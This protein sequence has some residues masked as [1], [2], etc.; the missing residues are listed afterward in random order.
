LTGDAAVLTIDADRG[1]V[2]AAVRDR[3]TQSMLKRGFFGFVSKRLGDAG[4]PQTFEI[5]PAAP[6]S[7][8]SASSVAQAVAIRGGDLCITFSPDTTVTPQ[9]A[10]AFI[11]AIRYDN[12]DRNPCL[13]QKHG[14][15][16]L[17]HV[18]GSETVVL[19]TLHIRPVDDPTEITV[20]LPVATVTYRPGTTEREP[21]SRPLARLVSRY[22]D[23]FKDLQ[24]IAKL[25]PESSNSSYEASASAETMFSAPRIGVMPL[26]PAHHV[27]ID[28]PDTD[29]W[30][31]GRVVVRCLKGWLSCCRI[32]LLSVEQQRI[33]WVTSPTV[34]RFLVTRDDA[35]G[36]LFL[37]RDPAA[38]ET[39]REHIGTLHLH[40]LRRASV[41][42]GQ[43]QGRSAKADASAPL[44]DAPESA[45]DTSGAEFGYFQHDAPQDLL[46]AEEGPLEVLRVDFIKPAYDGAP[47]RINLDAVRY[48]CSCIGFWTAR[49]VGP[50]DAATSLRFEVS[51]ADARNQSNAGVATIPVDL[52]PRMLTC[53]M[54]ESPNAATVNQW[55]QMSEAPVPYN[56]VLA[57]STRSS[58][59]AT[60]GEPV[61]P[62]MNVNVS[63]KE[64]LK[65][66]TFVEIFFSQGQQPKDVLSLK[67]AGTN[68]VATS[69]GF[70]V[71]GRE[72]TV[73]R[74]F[75]MP[76]YIRMDV[77][78]PSKATTFK[79][80]QQL[81]RCVHFRIDADTRDN[82]V[83]LGDRT[84]TVSL[85][86]GR[87][88][89]YDRLECT[90]GH[91]VITVQDLPPRRD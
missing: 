48:L 56:V 50:Y 76:H 13:L 62:T 68:F 86:E 61:F 89:L 36:D 3:H 21:W 30:D 65:E 72:G 67:F 81:L 51:I 88:D 4:A 73:G 78:T 45:Q 87:R 29:F 43:P 10:A 90:V 75:T 71:F 91:F 16:R 46:G 80:L 53:P 32:D 64:K 26:L 37:C 19:F 85:C 55:R 52:H 74:L 28:D 47:E 23:K 42:A 22:R 18:H 40:P 63:E 2:A 14:R 39:V 44:N 20:D 54:A 8:S 6:N 27:T 79:R 12:S 5:W 66:G 58:S 60:G 38:D 77:Q 83:V 9:L 57:Y 24:P 15:L 59:A 84:L 25:F 82:G 17:R 35:T 7:P 70:L 1:F 11:N 33:L 31:G 49:D 69:D 34:S 41:G